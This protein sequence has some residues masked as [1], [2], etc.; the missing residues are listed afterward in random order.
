ML[1]QNRRQGRSCKSHQVF[2]DCVKFRVWAPQ[3]DLHWLSDNETETGPVGGRPVV[4]SGVG[5]TLL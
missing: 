4:A 1:G 2:C 5:L 3:N